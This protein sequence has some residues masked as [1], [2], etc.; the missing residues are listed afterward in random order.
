MKDSKILESHANCDRVQDPYSFR[1][2]PQVHGAVLEAYG[3]LSSTIGIEINSAT[4]NP[5]I[6]PNPS[7]PG[8]NEVISQGNFHGEILSSMRR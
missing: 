8:Q 2:I 1:C 3:K 5:L 6:F 7:N 4:D